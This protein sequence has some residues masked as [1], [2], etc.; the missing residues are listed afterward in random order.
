LIEK[1]FLP[2]DAYCVIGLL[3]KDLYPRKGWNFVFG[4]S[5]IHH[6]SGVFSLAR[7]DPTF[8]PEDE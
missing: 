2:D 6:R 7:Y 8:Y 4:M 1:D 5:R 3:N